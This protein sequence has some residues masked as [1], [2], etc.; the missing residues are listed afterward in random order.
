MSGPWYKKGIF[1][2][3]SGSFHPGIRVVQ[4]AA[5]H[6]LGDIGPEAVGPL[7]LALKK[8][9]RNLRLGAIGALAEIKDPGAVSALADMMKDPGSEVRWQAAIALGEMGSHEAVA[10]LLRGLEDPDKY[11]RYGSAISLVKNGYQP[12]GD[13]RMGLVLCGHAGLGPVTD[14]GVS[15]PLPL[16][17]T[18]SAIPTVTSGS[19]R[20]GFLAI[21]VTGRPVRPSSDRWAM[22][23]GRCGGKRPLPPRSAVSRR[24][25][26][27]AG[28]TRGRAYRKIR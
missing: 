10:P 19:M 14:H 4:S 16:L 12:S 27:P 9:N 23:T 21:S 28:Y 22:P 24:C 5:V 8:K 3:L 1:P 17:R 20:S 6:A 26:C 7:V 25:T 15:L 18:S 13:D 2:D 11:V